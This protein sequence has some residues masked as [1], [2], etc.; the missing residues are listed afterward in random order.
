MNEIAIAI[1]NY[2]GR[3]HLETF[4]PTVIENAG[5]ADVIVID[6]GS[7]D[8]SLAYLS[9][10]YPEIQIIA[11]PKNL[12]FAGGYNQGLQLVPHDLFFLLN[13]DVALTPKVVETLKNFLDLHPE[14]AAC[15]PKILSWQEK[16]LFDYA[17]A[18]GGFLDILGYPFCR[19][20]IFDEIEKDLGQYEDT[21]AV[22]WVSGAAMMVRSEVFLAAG[23]F[24][25]LF[26]AHMEEIDLCWRLRTRGHQLMARSSA[27]VYHLGGG[28]LNRQSPRKTFLNFRNSLL[29]LAKNLPLKSMVWKIPLRLLLDGAAAILLLKQSGPAHVWAICRAHLDFYRLFIKYMGKR[30]V[31]SDQTGPRSILWNYFVKKNKSFESINNTKRYSFSYEASD[32][33]L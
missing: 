27:T 15:Q 5:P 20:R 7:T 9:A 8:D 2:N 13:N 17:G 33:D 16:N 21:M 14:V 10:S 6:N 24:D 28:T 19:G 23:G 3:L 1:L 32:E 29:L 22:H 26:F 4:L 31:R 11:L 30:F 25:P 18:A 12:G